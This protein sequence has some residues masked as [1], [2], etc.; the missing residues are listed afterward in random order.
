[1]PVKRNSSEAGST[2]SNLMVAVSARNARWI[3]PVR[4]QIAEARLQRELGV[5]S[6]LA[7]L[8]VGRGWRDP[9]AA[10]KFLNPS[11]DD[12]HDPKLLPDYSAARD[13]I[14]AA[15]E[16]GDLIYIHGDYD[17]DGVTS[18]AIL[19]RFLRKIGCKVEV[20]VPHRMKEGY[21]IHHSAVEAANALGAKL[22]L[23]C[24]CGGSAVEQ[25]RQARSYGMKVVVTDHH[26]LP[27]E[28]PLAEAIINPHRHDSI[29]PYEK[30]SGAGVAFKLCEGLTEEVGFDRRMFYKNFLDLAA[31]G[32]IADVMDLDGENRLI[33]RFGLQRLGET[34][35]AGL[36]A[37]KSVAKIE[38]AVTAYH[39]GYVLGPRLNAAGRIDDAALSLG[40]LLEN[41]EQNALNLA[42]QIDVLNLAR[43]EE[44]ERICQLAIQSVLDSNQEDKPVIVVSGEGWHKGI[45]GIVAGRLAELFHRPTFVFSIDPDTGIH[46]GSARSIPGFHLANAIYENADLFLGGGGHAEA[47]GCSFDGTR[48]DE[49]RGALEAYADG[50]LTPEML[51]RVA[52]AD[53]HVEPHE[54]TVKAIREL[55]MMEPFGRAN[56][57]PCF[58]ARSIQFT[59]IKGTK[60]PDV[61]Q[62]G[63]SHQGKNIRGITFKLGKMLAERPTGFYADVLFQPKLEEYLGNT[64]LKWHVRDFV[65]PEVGLF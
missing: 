12:L 54:I 11:L 32:T 57:D 33:A 45:V 23:T 43:R 65:E 24:D 10:N 30:L 19:T 53:L 29:Y 38:G 59:S 37:L 50:Q 34:K 41:D 25:I 55:E 52:S 48:A 60:N 27:E 16:A 21:G 44:Q 9:E 17:V 39:V 5:S 62:L 31:L 13:T 26:H 3:V 40:L 1:M 47:A 4:D 61:V 14:L 18:A 22:F 6:L 49:V 63:L 7:G 58:V 20:H 8:L 46:H 36:R 28:L 2:V 56:P 15:R 42:T 64:L 35:K 51:E